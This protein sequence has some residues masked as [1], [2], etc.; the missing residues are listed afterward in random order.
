M[1]AILY[2]KIV[3]AAA[4]DADMAEKVRIASIIAR[5]SQ[6]YMEICYSGGADILGQAE[7]EGVGG[8][9]GTEVADEVG[10]RVVTVEAV[11]IGI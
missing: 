6:G 4:K 11:D 3:C 1:W 7:S 5:K 8:I 9:G 10:S 2:G